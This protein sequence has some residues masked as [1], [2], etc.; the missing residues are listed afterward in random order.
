MKE[1][2]KANR[3]SLREETTVFFILCTLAA[4]AI[5][6]FA[7]P[8]PDTPK[9]EPLQLN[10]SSIS[11]GNP[12]KSMIVNTTNLYHSTHYNI[13]TPGIFGGL[14]LETIKSIPEDGVLNIE[15]YSSAKLII[16]HYW[17]L[18]KDG[19]YFLDRSVAYQ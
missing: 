10:F 14:Y 16:I 11:F 8:Y 7:N 6:Y 9:S 19:S 5:L 2:I 4:I 17:T 3:K 13:E 12:Y 1:E 18:L 15:V